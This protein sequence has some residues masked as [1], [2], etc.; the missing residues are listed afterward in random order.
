LVNTKFK[1]IREQFIETNE[2]I[3][4]DYIH[5]GEYYIRLIYDENGNKKWDPGNYLEKKQ[6]ENVIYYPTKL[7]I[8]ANWSLI[9]TFNL[10]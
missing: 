5:P 6:P 4:F 3:L 8:R 10:E 2:K 1:L 9:E 7:E